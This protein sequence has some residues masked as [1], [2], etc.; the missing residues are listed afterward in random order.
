MLQKLSFLGEPLAIIF[1]VQQHLRAQHSSVSNIHIE[2]LRKM[3]EEGKIPQAI[4]LYGRILL[5][6][7]NKEKAAKYFKKAMDI[8]Q[9]VK[10][11]ESIDAFFSPS[12][13]QPWELYGS[14]MADLG[15]PDAARD[16]VEIGRNEYDHARAYTVL[17]TT[18]LFEKDWHTAEQYLTKSAMDGNLYDCYRLGKLYLRMVLLNDSRYNPFSASELVPADATFRRRYSQQ[19]FKILAGNWMSLA[20][21]ANNSEAAVAIA[22]MLH[23]CGHAQKA[24]MWLDRAESYDTCPY[25]VHK[26]RESWGDRYIG[27]NILHEILKRP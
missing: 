2:A 19:V 12:E 16:A 23:A 27:R 5:A 4:A 22:C 18:A 14:T 9:P 24:L 6:N 7:G 8:S 20:V 17:A 26:L 13:P 11:N 10:Y 25:P 3:A 15:D 21:T 1:I